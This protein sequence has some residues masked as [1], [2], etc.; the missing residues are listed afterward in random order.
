LSNLL[1][2][3]CG[4]LKSFV[5]F[6]GNGGTVVS[7]TSF[8][9]QLMIVLLLLAPAAPLFQQISMDVEAAGPSRHLY[10]FS[11]GEV[12]KIATY[13]GG[14]PDTSVVVD[15][16]NGAKVTDV[17]MT[18]AGVSATGWSQVTVD[19]RAGWSAGESG[20]VDDRSDELSL[21]MSQVQQNLIPYAIDTNSLSAS[22]SWY[23]NGSY[24]IRQPHTS[25]S[26]ENR[27]SNQVQL[28]ST[29]FSSRSQGA[30]LK[31]HDWLFLSKWSGTNFNNVVQRLHPNNATLDTVIHLEQAS[32]TLP[33]DPTFD[34]AYGFR[35]W[36]I[37]DDERM[38]GIFTTYR[39]FYNNQVSEQYHRVLEFDIRNDDV[40]TCL[41]SYDVSPQ[42]GDY[43][44][45][46]YDK[47]R[48]LVWIVH[49]S[50]RRIVSY[51]FDSGNFVR[52]EYMYN[53]QSSSSTAECGTSS[54][55]VRGLVA[56]ND[57]FYMRCMKD[58]Y[59]QNRDQLKT[60]AISGTTNL[61]PQPDEKI[62]Y[63]MG[64]G[65]TFDGKRLITVD[66]GW[67]TSSSSL[68]YREFGTGLEYFTVP[69]PGTTTWFGETIETDSDVLSI[70]MKNYWSAVSQGDRVD[71]WV[72]ADNG[73]HWQQVIANETMHLNHPGRELVWKVQLI[74]ST[75]VSWWINLEYSTSYS[76]T[77]TWLSEVLQVGTSVG[78]VKPVWH[79][80][81]PAGTEIELKVTNDQ[82]NTWYDASNDV[83]LSFPGNTASSTIQYSASLSSNNNTVTPFLTRIIFWYEEG[84][85][86]RPELDIGDD[87]DWNWRS[88]LFLNESSVV[89]SDSSIVGDEVVLQPDLVDE[90]NQHIDRNGVGTSPVVI[91]VKASSPGRVSISNLDIT[92]KM[93]TRALDVSIDGGLLVPDG[94]W[95][96]M[97]TRVSLGDDAEEITEV[98]VGLENPLG[99]DTSYRWAIG[100]SCS[101]VDP[102][103]NV[104]TYDLGNCTSSIG[105]GGVVTLSVPILLNWS[106]DDQ[107]SLEAIISLSD[108]S[109]QQVVDWTTID[110]NLRIENDIEL[111]AMQVFEDNGRAL[112]NH[113]WVRGGTGIYITGQLNFEGSAYFPLPGEFDLVVMGQNVTLDGD[114]IGDEIELFR[115]G[116]PA[117]GGYNLSFTSPV[118]STAGGMVMAV[119]IDNISSLSQHSNPGY[120][121]ILLIFD[122]NSPLVLSADPNGV[123]VHAGPASPG[124]QAITIIIQ[125]SVD[126]PVEIT[127]N[128]WLGCKAGTHNACSDS[129][130]N[131]FPEEIEYS[132]KQ[133]T[134]PEIQAGGI[135]IFQGI[136]DDS[137]LIHGQ[138]VTF[139]VTGADGQG[140]QLAMGGVSVCPD[141]PPYCGI[142]PGEVAPR[143]N[144]TL[145]IYTIREEF[146]PFL[147]VDQSTIIGHDDE[148]PLHPGVQYSVL[149]NVSD[150]NGWSDITKIQISLT[151]DFEDETTSIFVELSV[152]AEGQ[153]LM[154]LVSGGNGLAV[155][156]IY[157][158]ASL[159]PLNNTIMYLDIKFQ[160]TWSF[161]EVWDT[162]GLDRKVPV[163]RLSDRPC[164]VETT[165]PCNTYEAG[166]GN[167]LWSLDNDFRFDQMPGH[168][169]A[170]EL[171]D[172]TNHY[173]SEGIETTI[174][175]GLAVRFSGR[176]LFS[177][178]ETP[179]PS[180]AFSVV[181][182]DYD[183]SWSTTCGDSGGFSIDF[184]VPEVRSGHLVLEA[185]LEDLPGIATYDV[186][187]S[188]VLRLAVDDENP[189][190]AAISMMGNNPG[191]AISIADAGSVEVLLDA[192]DDFGFS[193]DAP[194]L[195]YIMKAGDAEIL[196]GS[197]PLAEKVII[198]EGED[199]FFWRGI[200]DFTDD[201]ATQILPTYSIE[202]WITGSDKVGN[203]FI[204]SMNNED[205][206]LA[207]WP[208]A[209]SGP[210]ISLRSS[211]S[212]IVWSNPSPILDEEV[213]LEIEVVNHG[214]DG[215][216]TLV[217]QKLIG[218][219][220]WSEEDRVTINSSADEKIITSLN[221]TAAGDVGTGQVYRLLILDSGVEMDR[222]SVTPL[223]ITENVQRDGQAL[224]TQLG[225]SGLS[226]IMFIIT[227]F[228]VSYA[229]YQMVVIR[230]IRRGD[231][232]I[233]EENI[234]PLSHTAEV[235]TEM[236]SKVLPVIDQL[237]ANGAGQGEPHLSVP[238]PPEGLPPG[239]T[240]EQWQH[241]GHQ[242]VQS[243]G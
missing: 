196:R 224:G 166:L 232:G 214:K 1:L 226:V 111:S 132:H 114:P 171:R 48:D 10:S 51:D 206:P 174:G 14:S 45:I 34:K 162:N 64:N 131:N 101:M 127:L 38:F 193:D 30:V 155:S 11:G 148:S 44:A 21:A 115:V 35:D 184:L 236:Q 191:D 135:N 129:N 212:L 205:S 31:N 186:E 158:Q 25:N 239:W 42:Y 90:F 69:A 57:L 43:S 87:G 73:T 202:V 168:V 2:H 237:P 71:H 118:E 8:R 117:F 175:A 63:S 18:L 231:L 163:V 107:T 137:M 223:M 22:S 138:I 208:F 50:Q 103:V 119:T 145:S 95:R 75:A 77:G 47:S 209:L 229:M 102:S 9:L 6:S 176:L 100:D 32:C 140:N 13:Q 173:N 178:D 55:L 216:V 65:L 20:A 78:K 169:K 62:I 187:T 27:F 159:E 86:D 190:I 79:S 58:E 221:T 116:N 94:V 126:P 28:S 85:P 240:E 165:N 98:S 151:E 142:R 88:L 192:S 161:P 204:S 130:F 53:F 228:A 225:E 106:W 194:I 200:F 97:V 234:D 108:D 84:Y 68:F 170:I 12:E 146:D 123:E 218:G 136:I 207:S 82:G 217:L 74:G 211:D 92:Y 5:A 60:W 164:D 49:N 243:Q 46:S 113:N 215:V 144:Q 52:G 199:D 76:L 41:N 89:A 105:S 109:G 238:I 16:P 39:Y 242:Y 99:K 26:T 167:D 241:Y 227:L 179:A 182:S 157:S 139:Y 7:A 83:E 37:T 133:L 91:A 235:E 156:N 40:W 29:S 183:N 121:T 4:E 93:Q 177:E 66:C 154:N 147:N 19:D 222:I 54:S 233:E 125:D 110:L 172:G 143:W 24:A 213:H 122:G 59:Y 17:E 124:G 36:T 61:I 195:H 180:G 189:V 203:P 201:G 80:S 23:D 153:P 198:D 160:L 128:Y 3:Q 188:P 112:T 141:G 81:E 134:S 185:T 70:N 197:S 152:D 220:D 149:L 120:N 56:N 181:L 96:N 104:I 219:K 210:D 230:R 67:S 72:S 15:L 33:P 150:R